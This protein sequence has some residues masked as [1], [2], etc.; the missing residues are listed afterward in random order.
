MPVGYPLVVDALAVDDE[1]HASW[2]W[3]SAMFAEGEVA[4]LA[5]L[6]FEALRGMVGA[7]LEAARATP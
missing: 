2:E 5:E 4:E 3:P 1:L 6:W 7:G